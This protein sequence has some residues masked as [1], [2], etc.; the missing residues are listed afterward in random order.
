MNNYQK[1]IGLVEIMVALLILAIGILGFIALQYRALEATSEGSYRIQ[2]INLARDLAERIRINRDAF[3][4]YQQQVQLPLNQKAFKTN[5]FSNN[6]SA[7]DLADFDVAQVANRAA[8]FGMTINIMNCQGNNNNRNC[9]Y[10][11]WGDSSA[12]D[13]TGTGDCTNGTAYNPASTCIIME[14]Y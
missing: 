13:G 5:C 6:C 1:G 4:T 10:V 12:T 3:S 7:V 14:A 2:A 9:I 8:S 11:A